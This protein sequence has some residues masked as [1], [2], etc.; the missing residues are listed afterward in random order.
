MMVSKF[1]SIMDV[2]AFGTFLWHCENLSFYRYVSEISA[3]A[4]CSDSH[5]FYFVHRILAYE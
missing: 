3:Y 5:N 4:W 2:L 1:F